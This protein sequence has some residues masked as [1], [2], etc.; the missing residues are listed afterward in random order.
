MHRTGKFLILI[1]VLILI[2]V[3][4]TAY[5]Q[6]TH[7]QSRNDFEINQAYVALSGVYLPAFYNETPFIRHSVFA[8]NSSVFRHDP[9]MMDSSFGSIVYGRVEQ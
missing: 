6:K 9:F 5:L 1:F 7:S 8:D 4:E 2:T 3:T